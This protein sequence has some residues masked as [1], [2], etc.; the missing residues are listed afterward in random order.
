MPGCD[1][2][3]EEQPQ[4]ITGH[5]IG[6]AL[7]HG[8]DFGVQDLSHRTTA[9]RDPFCGYWYGTR[10]RSIRLKGVQLYGGGRDT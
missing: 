3:Y 5:A 6:S 8:Q 2:T 9:R 4:D 1:V 10:I 7:F